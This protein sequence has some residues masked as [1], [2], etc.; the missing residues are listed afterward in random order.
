MAASD[1]GS[2]G[3][4]AAPDAS[5]AREPR[6]A[7]SLHRIRDAA[8][9]CI[10]AFDDAPRPGQTSTSEVESWGARVTDALATLREAV[11]SDARAEA[12]AVTVRVDDAAPAPEADPGA[13]PPPAAAASAPPARVCPACGQRAL[14]R[15]RAISR[16]EHVVPRILPLRP[17]R[18]H[19]C[20]WRGWRW[21]AAQPRD[22][23]LASARIS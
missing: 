22:A 17:W 23:R 9:A 16:L 1:A 14:L 8:V 20:N 15:S 7:D 10:A 13:P 3:A 5:A 2:T 11:Q 4:A 6:D 12:P 19:E 18:C 21:G